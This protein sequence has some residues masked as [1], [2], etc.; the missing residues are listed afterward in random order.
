MF[1]FTIDFHRILTENQ[2]VQFS[3]LACGSWLAVRLQMLGVFMIAAV[4]TIAVL[5]HQFR[6]VNAG[7]SNES[8]FF[9][10]NDPIHQISYY[11]VIDC[12]VVIDHYHH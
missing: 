9:D 5:E 4:A 6:S 10:R 7:K 2:R 1:R 8:S 12:V 11:F 3:L